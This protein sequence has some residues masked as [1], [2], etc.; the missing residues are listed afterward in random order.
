[1]GTHHQPPCPPPTTAC[2]PGPQATA[3]VPR[4]SRRH[5]ATT[6]ARAQG[7]YPGR[8]ARGRLKQENAE[9]S[10]WGDARSSPP[11]PLPRLAA[12]AKGRPRT[13]SHAIEKKS[14]ATGQGK[15]QGPDQPPPQ[16]T[17]SAPAPTQPSPHHP[18]TCPAPRTGATPSAGDQG[19]STRLATSPTSGP[20]DDPDNR[21]AATAAAVP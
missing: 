14:P 3:A 17:R 11:S 12:Q 13:G 20:A 1:M 8:E 6:Y 19:I 2:P 16:T 5:P 9:E 21:W 7:G 18:S 15:R 10:P 4:R